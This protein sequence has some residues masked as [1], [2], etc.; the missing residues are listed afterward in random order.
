MRHTIVPVA[1][2][3]FDLTPEERDKRLR[4]ERCE[5]CG[6]VPPNP[7]LTPARNP[8]MPHLSRMT[9]AVET[10]GQELRRESV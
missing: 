7:C 5:T 3:S 8:S 10:Y 1:A 6:A 9:A 4:N 2:W